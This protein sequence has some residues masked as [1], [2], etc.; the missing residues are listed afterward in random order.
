VVCAAG[1]ACD[2]RRETRVDVSDHRELFERKSDSVFEVDRFTARSV[3]R[4]SPKI[5]FNRFK[6]SV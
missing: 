1:G 5:P 4:A 3:G 2:E 6:H